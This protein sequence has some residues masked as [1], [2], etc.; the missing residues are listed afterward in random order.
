[1]QALQCF[2]LYIG[3]IVNPRKCKLYF[4]GFDEQTKERIKG[5]TTFLEGPLPFKYM[6]V[7]LTSKQLSSHHYMNLLD[8]IIGRINHWS[9]RLLSYTGRVQLIKSVSFDITNYWIQCFPLPKH[10]IHKIDVV[11]RSFL[12]TGGSV[13]CR[14]SR[15]AWKKVCS[16]RKH[17]GLNIIDLNTWNSVTMMKL[18]W[19]LCGKA[20]NLSVKWLHTYYIKN[21]DV[22][23]MESKPSHSWI[24]KAILKQRAVVNWYRLFCGN[25]AR[26]RAVMIL[27][28]AFQGRLATKDRMQRLGVV[29][30]ATCCFCSCE[31]TLNHIFYGCAELKSIGGKY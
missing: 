21:G 27:W 10:V 28:L 11:C 16:P 12:W 1:M 4:G 24:I 19:N 30:N 9:N 15:V 3:L 14:K 26:P 2:S 25:V 29:Q 23:Q 7:P 8:R 13:I 20:N 6:G 18:L 22:M 5:L 31:E 17:G